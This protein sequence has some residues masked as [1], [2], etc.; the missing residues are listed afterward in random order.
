MVSIRMLQIIIHVNNAVEKEFIKLMDR[1]H[2]IGFKVMLHTNVL[3]M[4]FQS[5]FIKNTKSTR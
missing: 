4:T 2:E 1:A 5:S 3:G